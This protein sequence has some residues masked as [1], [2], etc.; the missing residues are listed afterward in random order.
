MIK[1]DFNEKIVSEFLMTIPKLEELDLE[2][3]NN[4][5]NEL[6]KKYTGFNYLLLQNLPYD[7]IIN[8]LKPSRIEDYTRLLVVATLIFI[9]GNKQED[10]FKLMKSYNIFTS[11]INKG[12]DIKESKFKLLFLNLL[13][14]LREYELATNL[15]Y[16]I[17]NYYKFLG[18]YAKGEDSLCELIDSDG[19]FKNHLSEYYNFL[20]TLDNN[21]LEEGGLTTDE[22]VEALRNT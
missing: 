12:L 21:T 20:L 22:V 11:S 6:Y 8:L 1:N 16:E 17:F 15:Q 7:E 10:Y 4:D 19:S 9:E 13:D 18:E 5:I 14:Y 2:T 3:F